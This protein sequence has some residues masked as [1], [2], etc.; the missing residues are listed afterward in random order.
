L[1]FEETINWKNH[2]VWVAWKD[3]KKIA[4]I[5]SDFHHQLSEDDFVKMQLNNRLLWKETLSVKG[6]LEMIN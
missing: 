1:P 5:V 2:V 6:M 4:N 3:R